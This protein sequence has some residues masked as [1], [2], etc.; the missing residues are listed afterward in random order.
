MLSDFL[1]EVALA[2]GISY[3][4][5]DIIKHDLPIK[6]HRKILLCI[7]RTNKFLPAY[8]FLSA[9]IRCYQYDAGKLLMKT[10][11]SGRAPTS[12]PPVSLHYRM[13]DGSQPPEPVEDD[14]MTLV[15]RL[16]RKPSSDWPLLGQ[17]W[18]TVEWIVSTQPDTVTQVK[19]LNWSQC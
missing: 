4:L 17:D 13:L 2:C 8:R 19:V 9:Y 15:D 5:N 12:N 10:V 1:L 11:F 18:A 7:E 3:Y 16:Q 6:C 14:I